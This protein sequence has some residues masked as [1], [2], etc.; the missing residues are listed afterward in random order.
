MNFLYLIMT[1]KIIFLAFGYTKIPDNV[2]N[3]GHE[4]GANGGNISGRCLVIGTT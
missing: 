4:S 3:N 1:W 2:G